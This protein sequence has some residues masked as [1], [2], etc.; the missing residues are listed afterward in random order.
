MWQWKALLLV[1]LWLQCLCLI[2]PFRPKNNASSLSPSRQ[3][4]VICTNSRTSLKLT[5]SVSTFR[6]SSV[7]FEILKTYSINCQT[8][9]QSCFSCCFPCAIRC[10]GLLLPRCLADFQSQLFAL[11]AAFIL[12][13]EH[14]CISKLCEIVPRLSSC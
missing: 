9:S 11:N 10:H 2:E 6:L 4:R 5:H 3:I 12:R 14:F 13:K 7:T 1:T 8:M